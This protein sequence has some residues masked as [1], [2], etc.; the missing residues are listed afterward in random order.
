[1]P[2]YTVRDSQTGKTVRFKWNAAEPP[3]DADM[4]EVFAA[5][6]TSPPPEDTGVTGPPIEGVINQGGET[7]GAGKMIV[8]GAV[9]APFYA[10]PYAG[11]AVGAAVGAA[12]GQTY[13]KLLGKDF[14]LGTMARDTAIGAG[15]GYAGKGLWKAATAV[16]KP[17][18][19]KISDTIRHGIQKGIRPSVAGKANFKQTEQ[20]FQKA[21]SA[22]ESIIGNKANLQ[23]TDDLGNA[24]KGELPKNLSQLAQAVDQTKRE[25]FRQYDDIIQKSGGAVDLAP[26]VSE[27]ETFGGGKIAKL[28]G[29]TGPNRAMELSENMKGQALTLSETQELIAA[30]NNRLQYFYKNPSPDL[31]GHAA[32]DALA[33]NRLRT[34]LDAAVEGSG[35][36]ALKNQYGALRSIEKEVS[37][38][39]TVDA[40]KNVK[41]LIDFADIASA[42]EA[43]RALATMN[44][45]SASASAAIKAMQ[46]YYRYLN[47]PNRIVGSMFS[48]AEKLIQKRAMP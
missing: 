3:T 11:P 35:Y 29:G 36:Q 34:A 4:E 14:D 24:V 22:V 20:Y 2:E 9:A 46:M 13:D 44:P 37:H 26:V 31:A 32:A 12:A 10:I 48:D 33:A 28:V 18:E 8:E 1:M 41:G 19:K 42:A 21:Q 16:G 38:R 47:N 39:A 5:S 45:G 15:L 17:L 23:F 43:A 27:L 25:I 7:S 6:R 30:L 40:R